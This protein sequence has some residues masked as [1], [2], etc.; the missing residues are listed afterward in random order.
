MTDKFIP[1]QTYKDREGREYVFVGYAPHALETVRA[2]FTIGQHL[3]GRYED[4][5]SS[6]REHDIVQTKDVW[7]NVYRCPLNTTGVRCSVATYSSEGEAARYA[8]DGGYLSPQK[9][10]VTI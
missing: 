10:T 4:G 9:I 6:F 5:K 7:V 3:T 8:H 1:G 2:V